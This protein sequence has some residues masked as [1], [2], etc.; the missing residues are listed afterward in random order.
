[1]FNFIKSIFSLRDEN[2]NKHSENANTTPPR[3]ENIRI[4]SILEDNKKK[5]I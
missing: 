1:M 2:S 4:S 5:F 3:D